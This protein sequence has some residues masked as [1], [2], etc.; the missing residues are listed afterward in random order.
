MTRSSGI[1]FVFRV[2]FA[3]LFCVAVGVGFW[4][5]ASAAKILPIP[6]PVQWFYEPSG[7]YP[8]ECISC[9]K[10]AAFKYLEDAPPFSYQ[11]FECGAINQK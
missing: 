7:K 6:S 2:V 11:C 1:P 5:L 4:W 10:R 8:V 9:G 3:F